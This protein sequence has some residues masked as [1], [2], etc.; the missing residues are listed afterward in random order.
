MIS[1]SESETYVLSLG[2]RPSACPPGGCHE[3][4]QKFIGHQT[5]SLLIY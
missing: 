5:F 3:I 4:P 1:E 2:T